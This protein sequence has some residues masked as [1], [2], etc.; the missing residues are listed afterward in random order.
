MKFPE[1]CG[2]SAS[3]EASMLNGARRVCAKKNTRPL[4]AANH[5]GSYLTALQLALGAIR[6][7]VAT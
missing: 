5:I 4:K 6:T 7:A 3:M 1:L 2:H